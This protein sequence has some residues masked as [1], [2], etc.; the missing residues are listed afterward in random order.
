MRPAHPMGFWHR[1]LLPGISAAGL[2]LILAPSMGVQASRAERAAT[3]RDRVV[4]ID[5][6]DHEWSGLT[7]PARNSHVALG[8]VND[9]EWL[10]LCV[11]AKHDATR[12]QLAASGVIVWLDAEKGKKNAFGIQFPSA[13]S[14]QRRGGDSP[15]ARMGWPIEIDVLGPGKN[16]VR[17]VGLDQAG[18]IRAAAG[19]PGDV[20]VYELKV[21]LLKTEE[22]PYAVGVEPGQVVRVSVE[23][24]EYR[25]PYPRGPVYPGGSV[26]VTIGGGGT[27]V[28]GGVVGGIPV[29]AVPAIRT[30]L[31]V[32]TTVLL[33]TK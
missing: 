24:P 14:F 8:F 17:T 7:T 18:G 6:S 10:C 30:P 22:H 27:A 3:W 29:G 33:A 21:P 28:A 11:L 15:D 12:A 19:M 16:K 5:G 25:G 2:A 9:G 13:R 20:F 1:I 31:S 23:T 32:Q 4:T 26:G